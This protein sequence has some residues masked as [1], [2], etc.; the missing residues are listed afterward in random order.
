MGTT[1]TTS[2]L[3]FFNRR[4]SLN[5]D[6]ESGLRERWADKVFKAVVRD[7]V[8]LAEAPSAG[9]DIFSYRKNSYGA[10]DY[11]HVAK[12]FATRARKV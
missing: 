3:T 9:E 5:R 10:E 7:N 12:E 11:A 2:L 6:V 8:A 1:S 4:K